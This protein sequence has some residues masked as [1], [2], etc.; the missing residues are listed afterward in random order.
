MDMIVDRETAQTVLDLL[1]PLHGELDRQVYDERMREELEVPRDRE[2]EVSVTEG[3]ERDLTQ[4]VCI[5]ENR[6]RERG[7]PDTAAHKF[8][9]A[10]NAANLEYSGLSWSGFNVFGDSK[11]IEKVKHLTQVE[12]YVT[13]LREEIQRLRVKLEDRQGELT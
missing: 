11:S 9:D 10:L 4:A 1:N 5:L 2:W 3:M 6:L 8:I 13:A 7:Q 12:N